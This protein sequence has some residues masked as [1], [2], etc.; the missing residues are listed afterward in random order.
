MTLSTWGYSH[1]SLSDI[2]SVIVMKVVIVKGTWYKCSNITVFKS[3][4]VLIFSCFSLSIND[5][6]ILISKVN[7]LSLVRSTSAGGAANIGITDDKITALEGRLSHHINE[8][9]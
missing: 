9:K 5:I 8:L 1:L 2:Y 7:D 6:R 4:V 3:I